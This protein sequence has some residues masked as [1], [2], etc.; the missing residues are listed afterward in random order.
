MKK[1]LAYPIIIILVGL[2]LISC[3]SFSQSTNI[4]TVELNATAT[5]YAKADVANF[6]ISV[7]ELSDTTVES[8][9]KVNQKIGLLLE[10]LL[11]NNVKDKNIKTTNLNIYPEYSYKDGQQILRGQRVTQSLYVSVD[12]LDD[13]SKVLSK[14]IDEISQISNISVNS[15]SFTKEDPSEQYSQS[16]ALAIENAYKKATEYAK[17][18]N[19]EVGS[20]IRISE[21]VGSS[22]SPTL[23]V[24]AVKALSADSFSASI[25]TGELEISTTVTVVY[26]LK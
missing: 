19:L 26:E 18:A 12:N 16:R 17:A 6:S 14:I 5:V 8:Q 25:P 24:E 3:Q 1:N 23:R 9:Q 20:A 11:T 15:I 22:Y 4:K 13:N 2:L 21:N 10:I 7:S